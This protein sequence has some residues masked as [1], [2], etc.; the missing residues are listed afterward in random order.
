MVTNPQGS[1]HCSQSLIKNGRIRAYEILQK[2]L[3]SRKPGLE[4]NELSFGKKLLFAFLFW[5][6]HVNK[7]ISCASCTDP[8][9]P[10]SLSVPKIFSPNPCHCEP[11]IEDSVTF[12]CTCELLHLRNW[13]PR[14]NYLYSAFTQPWETAGCPRSARNKEGFEKSLVFSQ[15]AGKVQLCWKGSLHYLTRSS[16]ISAE[17]GNQGDAHSFF[18]LN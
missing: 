5:G 9:S 17:D 13:K 4:W 18:F 15:A 3:P 14:W 7:N 12:W 1:I 6:T 11:W 16:V 8:H 10:A 2:F